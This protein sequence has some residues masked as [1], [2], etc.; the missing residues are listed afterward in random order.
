MRC[1]PLPY[2]S[3]NEKRST[4]TL[5]QVPISSTENISSKS[6]DSSE[7]LI[8]NKSSKTE[9]DQSQAKWLGSLLSKMSDN[10]CS[11]TGKY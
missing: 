8:I 4:E 9:N 3:S 10:L 6:K 5:K 2:T 1:R 11:S 7:Q